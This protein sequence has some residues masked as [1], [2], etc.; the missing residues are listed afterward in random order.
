[1]KPLGG[2]SEVVFSV[3]RM[4]VGFSFCLHGVEKMFGVHDHA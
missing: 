4:T 3:A 1:M 2:V